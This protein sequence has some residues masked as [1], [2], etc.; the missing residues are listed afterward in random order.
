MEKNKINKQ[1]ITHIV[2]GS[3]ALIC[4]M[5]IAIL[6][7]CK[8][9]FAIDGFNVAVANGRNK[10]LTAFFKVFTHLGSGFI[11]I[12]VVFIGFLAMFFV[13]K[14]KRL[15]LFS[16]AFFGLTCVANFIIKRIIRRIRPEHLMI[17]E[18]TGFSFPSGHSMMSFA[19]FAILAFFAYLFIKN[20]PLK[21][22]LMAVCGLFIVLIGFSRIYLGVHYLTDILAGWLIT[23][24]MFEAFV[25][26]YNT[27]LL[28]NID[29][30]E[31]YK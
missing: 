23:F 18:E 2:L 11:A 5:V 4:F 17:I 21:Y 27:K 19:L 7:L 20:K 31:L 13:F 10:G 3:L 8:H 14:H 6:V 1:L 25:I 16:V 15:S 28:V 9:T 12:P 26:I 29:K 24:A 22:S 30:K